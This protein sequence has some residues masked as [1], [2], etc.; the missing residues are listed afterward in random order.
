MKVDTY[1]SSHIQLKSIHQTCQFLSLKISF[2]RM[3]KVKEK[4]RSFFYRM[5][6]EFPNTFK[7][8]G[9][10]LF[11]LLCDTDVPAKQ[12][13]QVKQHIDTAKHISSVSRKNNSGRREHQTLLTLPELTDR[14][15]KASEFT[16]DLATC[17]LRANI[18]L[19]KIRNPNVVN[20]LEKHTKYAA[21]SEFNL[22]NNYHTKK[23][24]DCVERMRKIAA[25]RYIWVS[26]DETTDCEQRAVANFVFGILG[27]E[28]HRGRSYLF[29]SSVLE[30]AVN[31]ST[32]AQF[33]DESI[34][35]LSE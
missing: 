23:Y 10:V 27:V 17:F 19:H 26:I 34:N 15:P 8:D 32:V 2:G 6:E 1:F 24:D 21:P 16:M 9:S 31:G 20:F 7:T 22:R 3:P 5:T 4:P 25:D 14:N 28:W 13:S 18:P 29:A 12:R 30:G 11:C 33:F 35:N